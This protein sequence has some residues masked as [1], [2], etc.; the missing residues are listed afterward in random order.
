MAIREIKFSDC[1]RST[2]VNGGSDVED[3]DFFFFFVVVSDIVVVVVWFGWFV[4]DGMCWLN[5][6]FLAAALYLTKYNKL[7]QYVQHY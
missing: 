3:E 2:A 6:Y 5:L 4:C 7:L 1:K